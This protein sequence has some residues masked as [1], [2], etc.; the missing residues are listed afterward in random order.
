MNTAASYIRDIQSSLPEDRASA[1]IALLTFEQDDPTGYT[2]SALPFN[3][4]QPLSFDR[5]FMMQTTFQRVIQLQQNEGT[6]YNGRKVGVVVYDPASF[7]SA[8]L[9]AEA[10]LGALRTYNAD[11]QFAYAADQGNWVEIIHGANGGLEEA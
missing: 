1:F 2:S 3:F 10:L 7:E 4:A 6:D 9:L 8:E 5:A 11:P